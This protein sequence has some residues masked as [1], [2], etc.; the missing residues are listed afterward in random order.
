MTREE[1]VARAAKAIG[2]GTAYD[3]HEGMPGKACSCSR[4]IAWVF[5]LPVKID[6]PLYRRWNGGW[7]ETTAIVRDAQTDLGLFTEAPAGDCQIGDL[8]VWPDS[9][10]KQGHVGLVSQVENG[11]PTKVIHC[12]RGN[13]RRTGDAI[14][15]TD[16]AV[17]AAN[18]AIIARWHGYDDGEGDIA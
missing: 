12:S 6:Q 13:W 8:L 9:V 11:H 2:T 17:F 16:P 1:A 4:F 5:G 3:L 14:Q 18:G 7:F 10:H 15:E